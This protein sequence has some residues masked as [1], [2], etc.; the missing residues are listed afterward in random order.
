MLI[1]VSIV[2]LRTCIYMGERG[3]EIWP[4]GEVT[5]W[6]GRVLWMLSN[7]PLLHRGCD[8]ALSSIAGALRRTQMPK[9]R[10]PESLP[11]NTEARR[12]WSVGSWIV[13]VFW[14]AMLL[15]AALF[16]WLR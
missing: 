1:Y 8:M 10:R 6:E 16:Y 11:E 3:S 7:A 12:P 4:K 5:S 2:T 13:P 9:E 14:L 15:F